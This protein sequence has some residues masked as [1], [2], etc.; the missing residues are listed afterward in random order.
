DKYGH[1]FGAYLG[2]DPTWDAGV[3]KKS[4]AIGDYTWIDS[5]RDGTQ[6][7]ADGNP[8]KPLAHVTVKLT[9]EDGN[10]VTDVLGNIVAEQQT[11]EDGYYL[12]DN[13][14]A[15]TYKVTFVLDGEEHA[16][17]TFTKALQGGEPTEDSDADRKTGESGPITLGD[18][19]EYLTSK[20]GN[21]TAVKAT[22]GVD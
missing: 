22:Q 2:I 16:A 19:N 5:D 14:E 15:G 12:F 8:E 18:A 13:L 9:D 3:V 4:Y 17:Y 11:G 10:D 1:E 21:G 20:T 7:D 6:T